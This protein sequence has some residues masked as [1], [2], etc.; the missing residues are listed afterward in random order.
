MANKNPKQT[1]PSTA[2][3]LGAKPDESDEFDPNKS[4]LVAHA[5][6]ELKIAG[7]GEEDSDY[8]GAISK[9][10]L[11]LITLFASQRHSG[12]SAELVRQIFAQLSDFEVLTP[13]TD[14][15]EEWESVSKEFNEP[16]WQNKR[17]TA[18]FS[19]DGGKTWMHVGTKVKGRSVSHKKKATPDAK[20]ETTTAKPKTDK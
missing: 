5:I 4:N 3:L 18:Y 16:M 13:I 20:E 11:D 12:G 14:D 8:G 9:C 6:R 17:G 15:P 19:K 2:P 1:A 7:I 10:V